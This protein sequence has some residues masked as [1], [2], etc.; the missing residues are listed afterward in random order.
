M[1][2]R[3][4]PKPWEI[5]P[6]QNLMNPQRVMDTI[7]SSGTKGIRAEYTR[8]RDIMQKRIKRGGLDIRIPKLRDLKGPGDLSKEFAR[9]NRLIASETT[10]AEGR[11]RIQIREIETLERHKFTGIDTSNINS[12]NRFMQWYREKYTAELPEGRKQI[13]D[14]DSAVTV[15]REEGGKITPES[16]N[17]AISRTFNK[18]IRDN[19]DE[20]IDE[21]NRIARNAKRREERYKKRKKRKENEEET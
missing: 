3:R 21:I 10:T 4:Q 19:S 7:K 1:P 20:D 14:S 9:L 11:R 12:F 8:L 2:K 18:Y 16:T 17:T 15:F 13:Y 5:E 6:D